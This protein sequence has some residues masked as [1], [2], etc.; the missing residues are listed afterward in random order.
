[1]DNFI[2]E[3]YRRLP[4]FEVGEQIEGIVVRI[5]NNGVVVKIQEN[6]YAW[7]PIAEISNSLIKHLKGYLHLGQPIRAK[8]IAIDEVQNYYTLSIKQMAM[9][10]RIMLRQM[11]KE[12]RSK[13]KVSLEII[14][15]NY[16]KWIAMKGNK[17]D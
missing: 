5:D 1:M 17:N 6:T 3:V 4:P 2:Q 14:F 9:H 15:K 13:N 10:D 12:N 7:L 8:I 16:P 11:E